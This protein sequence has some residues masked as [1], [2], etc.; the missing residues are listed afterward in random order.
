MRLLLDTHVVLWWLT[1]D[2]GLATDVKDRIDAE[3]DVYLSPV[4]LWEVAIKQSLGKLA[5]PADLAERI[6]DAELRELPILHD[7]AIAAGRLPTIH[8]DP[9]DRMLVAQALHEGLTLVT[10]DDRIQKYDVPILVV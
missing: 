4:T 2:P 1:D 3:P 8:R 5:G 9:F 10:R 7:H 6:R